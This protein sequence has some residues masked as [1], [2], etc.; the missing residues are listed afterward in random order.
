MLALLA[1]DP[2]LLSRSELQREVPSSKQEMPNI[3]DEIENL[4]AVG[5]LNVGRADRSLT[6]SA[7]YGRA[8]RQADMSGPDESRAIP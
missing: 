1:S 4:R 2:H 3:D 6:R 5:L 7:L 8:A